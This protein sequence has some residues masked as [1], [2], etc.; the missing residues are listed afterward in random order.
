VQAG[1]A[2]RKRLLATL[3]ERRQR[4]P[5][6]WVHGLGLTPSTLTVAYPMDSC[7]S[8]TWLAGARWGQFW[9]WGAGQRLWHA[10]DGW[11]YEQPSG[12][13]HAPPKRSTEAAFNLAAYD[14]TLFGR[15]LRN[16]ARDYGERTLEQKAR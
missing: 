12:G 6:L 1:S 15:T 7:D 10:G 9:T 8:S 16:M 4:W 14:A 13:R 2:D 5:N 3:A 11:L